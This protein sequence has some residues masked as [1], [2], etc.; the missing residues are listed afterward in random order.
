M[1]LPRAVLPSSAA[2]RCSRPRLPALVP[3]RAS[4]GPVG[5]VIVGAPQQPS[6]PVPGVF[7]AVEAAIQRTFNSQAPG[8]RNDWREVEGAWVLYP[9]NNTQPG[10]DH[11]GLHA[12]F[13]AVAA[14]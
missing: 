11:V 6:N 12:K 13:S 5:N 3:P 14:C 8:Q 4:P 9:P 10:A 7:S 1:L 2:A